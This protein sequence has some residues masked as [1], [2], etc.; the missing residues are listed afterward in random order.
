M[1][2]ERLIHNYRLTL[3]KT[4]LLAKIFDSVIRNP[5]QVSEMKVFILKTIKEYGLQVYLDTYVRDGMFL[6]ANMLSIL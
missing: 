3:P 4:L 1:G 6:S 5:D 2:L